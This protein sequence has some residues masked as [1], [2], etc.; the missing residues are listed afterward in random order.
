[1][2]S[3]SRFAAPVAILNTCVN[4]VAE[5]FTPALQC[6]ECPSFDCASTGGRRLQGS[7]AKS[8]CLRIDG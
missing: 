1:M 6:N 3:Q 7:D 5:F 4:D 2:Q 8:D